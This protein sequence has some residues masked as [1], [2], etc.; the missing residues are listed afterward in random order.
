VR[1]LIAWVG[2]RPQARNLRMELL[3]FKDVERVDR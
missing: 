1:Q 2:G 3:S